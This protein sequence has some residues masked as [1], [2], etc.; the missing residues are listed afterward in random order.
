MNTSTL[1][2][3]VS[4][5]V[6]LLSVYSLWSSRSEKL[7]EHVREAMQTMADDIRDL[8]NT[9]EERYRQLDELRMTSVR[10]KDDVQRLDNTVGQL[11]VMVDKMWV[12]V[13]LRAIDAA[14]QIHSPNPI[15]AE[16]DRLVTMFVAGTLSSDDKIKLR[17]ML[18]AM[19][20]DE[21]DPARVQASELIRYFEA[22]DASL[23]NPAVP[24]MG[25]GR[26]K[27]A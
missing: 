12:G 10:L 18:K 26:G 14:L 2:L 9:S 17:T 16:R 22:E 20:A 21:N 5:A 19:V 8:K 24:T 6:F 11:K 3:I 27:P 15:H 23:A 25:N 13:G 4:A 7:K 1:S